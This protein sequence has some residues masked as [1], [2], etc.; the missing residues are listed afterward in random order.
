VGFFSSLFS[1]SNPVLA[2]GM[3][4]AG[5]TS[6]FSNTLGQGL[7]SQAGGFYSD[8]LGGD[9]SK[10]SKL[11][12]PQIGTMTKQGQQQK[13]TMAEFGT[14]SGGL[15]SKGQTVDDSTRA[16]ISNAIATLTGQAAGAAGSMGTSLIDTGLKSLG[17]QVD[18]SQTQ[19]DNWSNSLFGKGITSAM[20][21]GESYGLG[22]ISPGMSAA[23]SG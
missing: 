12:A 9:M 19:M 18:M 14:R 16:N 15:S 10:I 21:T 5:Q 22:K 17:M 6:Q 2:S 8:I 23:V 11:I 4:Q 7:T 3:K 20:A 1:G 13:K